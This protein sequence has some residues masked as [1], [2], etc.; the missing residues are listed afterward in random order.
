MILTVLEVRAIWFHTDMDDRTDDL[1]DSILSE[2]EKPAVS[3][4]YESVRN[5]SNVYIESSH[6]LEYS[7]HG[8]CSSGFITSSKL[9][10]F[11]N[12]LCYKIFT[13]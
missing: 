11:E 3:R 13:C 1:A 7:K 10:L 5:T 2:V 12:I 9:P 6:F 4:Y 8:L